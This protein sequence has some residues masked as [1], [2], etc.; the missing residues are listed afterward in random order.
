MSLEAWGD[1]GDIQELP[2]GCWSEGTVSTVLDC[3][4]DLIAEPVYED[5]NVEKGIS[6]R[7]LA[8][9]TILQGEAGLIPTSGA[10]YKEAEAMFRE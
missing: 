8:R 1:D 4:K 10:L 5:G 3:I 2:K 9:L 7:F 6:V